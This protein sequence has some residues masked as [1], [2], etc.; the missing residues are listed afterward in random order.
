MDKDPIKKRNKA[1]CDKYPF[2][3][4][5]NRF[6]GRRIT[7]GKGYWP[8]SPDDDPEYDYEFTELDAMPEGW[9]LAFGKDLCRELKEELE[10]QGNGALDEYRITQIKEKYG[11]LCW[12]SN[13]WTKGIDDIINKYAELSRHTCIRCGKPA[14]RVTVGWVS[15]YCDDCC[16]PDASIPIEQFFEEVAGS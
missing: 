10:R 8:G 11:Y 9:R 2:L 16:P 15:P 3:I 12:Y 5:S 4:P 1:L 13:W 6:N 7:Q 14:T